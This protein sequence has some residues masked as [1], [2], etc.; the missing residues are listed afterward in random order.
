MPQNDHGMLNI[1]NWNLQQSFEDKRLQQTF[2][3]TESTHTVQIAD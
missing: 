2:G 1:H 3:I